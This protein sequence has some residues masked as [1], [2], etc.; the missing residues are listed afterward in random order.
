MF[1]LSSLKYIFYHFA[2]PYCAETSTYAGLESCINSTTFQ[3]PFNWIKCEN[4]EF[5]RNLHPNDTNILFGKGQPWETVVTQFHL[6][7]DLDWMNAL[8]MSMGLFGVL[9][10]GFS[11]GMYTDRY[12]RKNTILVWVGIQSILLVILSVM[13]TAMGFL[14]LRVLVLATMVSGI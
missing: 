4:Y 3:E 5:D 14:V 11:G 7:C 6:V 1:Q 2:Q 13:P 12:G 10:G 8:L 9:I